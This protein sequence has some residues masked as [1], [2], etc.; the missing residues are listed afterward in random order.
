[1]G[2]DPV[3][4]IFSLP[5]DT[6]LVQLADLPAQEDYRWHNKRWVREEGVRIYVKTVR[7]KAENY[8]IWTQELNTAFWAIKCNRK[9]LLIP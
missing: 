7:E 1:M 8:K 5:L 3:Q 2:E 6:I 4:A 9:Q